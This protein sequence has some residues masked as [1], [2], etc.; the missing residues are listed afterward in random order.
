VH[1]GKPLPDMSLVFRSIGTVLLLNPKPSR[2]FRASTSKLSGS[3]S[4]S[5]QGHREQALEP[6]LE[7]AL[8]SG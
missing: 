6:K 7:H 8:R 3:S 5:Q 4:A 1:E 2:I